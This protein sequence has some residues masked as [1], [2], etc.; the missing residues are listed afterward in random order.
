MTTRIA[1]AVLALFVAAGPA[2]AQLPTPDEVKALD[3]KLKN[4]IRAA[5]H[6]L[7][8]RYEHKRGGWAFPGV[9]KG[10]HPGI[11]ALALAAI[12]RSPDGKRYSD[13][14]PF[15]RGPID[16]LLKRQQKDGSINFQGMLS[17]YITSVAIMALVECRDRGMIKDAE[18]LKKVQAALKSMG[19]YLVELQADEG[20]G[21]TKEDKMYGGVGYGGDRR[22]D[23]SNT[24]LAVEAAAKAGVSKDD[25]FFKKAVVFLQRTQNR[26]ESNDQK[27]AG[28]DGGFAYA[29]GKSYGG[30]YK[31]PDGTTGYVSYGSMT[32]AGV[33]SFIYAGLEWDDPRV[34]S[35]MG[36]ISANYTVEKHPKMAGNPFHG[37]YYY[38]HTFAKTMDLY[39]GHTGSRVIKDKEGIK[40]HW[41]YDL[42]KHLASLQAEDGSFKNTG[43]AKWMEGE[44]ILATTY[45]ILALNFCKPVE[46]KKKAPAK[47]DAKK[48]AEKK[49]AKQ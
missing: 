27:W 13:E 20:E 44:R 2:F 41:A 1:G 32:Y 39:S 10:T 15:I 22:P 5:S 40:H 16:S 47:Q 37:Y 7:L 4:V 19:D 24:Q 26:S 31:K 21:Y 29:P 12:V 8:D 18:R 6:Y 23:L 14:D 9:E 33:K 30:T 38:L 25:P 28:D 42:G 3:G 49:P 43:S 34:Q 45:A 46:L 11:D 48:G 17:N 36:W 35:A